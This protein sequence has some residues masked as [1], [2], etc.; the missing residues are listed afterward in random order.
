LVGVR[1]EPAIDHGHIVEPEALHSRSEGRRHGFRD[2][3][4]DHLTTHRCHGHCEGP[5]AGSEIDDKRVGAQAV[6]AERVDVLGRIE[7]G[8]AVVASHIS[9]VEV[10]LTRVR[11]LVQPPT[12]HP[13]NLRDAP[14]PGNHSDRD[15][16]GE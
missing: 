12:L 2:V 15:A 14:V 8:L 7:S 1:E 9:R 5:G 10:L 13:S 11:T 4:R 6:A 16:G 3:D